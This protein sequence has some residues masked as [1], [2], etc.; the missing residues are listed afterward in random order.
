MTGHYFDQNWKLNSKIL[1]FSALPPPHN[2][3]S[4]AVHLL[5]SLKEWG[6]DKKVFSI[7]LDNASS[8][9]SM[10]DIVKSQ[11]LLNDD[12]LC[13]DNFSMSDVLLTSLT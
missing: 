4:V 9:D 2:G 3:M 13:E 1:S 7:T 6:V 8:N 12:L 11:L 10:Q 5:E